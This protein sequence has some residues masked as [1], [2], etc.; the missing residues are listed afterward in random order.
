[1]FY[2][3]S[4]LTSIDLS[5][6]NTSN[7]TNMAYMFYHCSGLTSLDLSNFDTSKVTNVKYMFG[8]CSGLTSLDLSGWDLTNVTTYTNY[9]SMFSNCKSLQYIYVCGCNQ[10]TIDKINDVKPEN[11]E[12]VFNAYV[13]NNEYVCGSEINGDFVITSVS[14][15]WTREDNTFTSNTIT[16]SQTTTQRIYFTV[17]QPT[18]MALDIDQSSE[19]SYDYLLI[20]KIDT[21]VVNDT[22]STN[23]YANWKGKSTGSI[24]IPVTTSGDH[25]IE[26]MYRKDNSDNSGRDNV[27]VTLKNKF[28]ATLQ[29]EIW[30]EV[31]CQDHS[32]YTG[33]VEYRNPQPL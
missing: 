22:T 19:S 17:S 5:N 13:F 3:C 33:N 28:D 12:I 16:H 10:A 30:R 1:M 26:L 23:N 21:T 4:G 2:D 20:S 8:Y 29:Y 11:A 25:F 27:I 31:D 18:T 9:S 7:V 14:G 24:E 15:N 32:I 6:L